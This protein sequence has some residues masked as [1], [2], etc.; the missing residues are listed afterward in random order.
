MQLDY[1][2]GVHE[3]PPIE[4][5]RHQVISFSVAVTEILVSEILPLLANCSTY[6]FAVDIQLLVILFFFE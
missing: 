2:I 1:R 3:I 6:Y 5:W 4:G